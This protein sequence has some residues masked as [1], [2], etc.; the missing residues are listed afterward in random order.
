VSLLAC[1]VF[2]FLDPRLTS[3]L[4][5]CI[6]YSFWLPLAQLYAL[7]LFTTLGVAD[8]VTA[9]LGHRKQLD[10]IR[11]ISQPMSSSFAAMPVVVS[12]AGSTYAFD[13]DV[14]EG[15]RSASATG[16]EGKK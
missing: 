14:E 6:P 10:E 3:H 7:S 2:S 8:K 15:S 9:T 4:N 5:S 1:S 12:D 11:A 13:V 16:E